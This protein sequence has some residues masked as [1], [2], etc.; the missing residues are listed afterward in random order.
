MDLPDD[1]LDELFAAGAAGLRF[2]APLSGGRADHLATKL[3][4]GSP[5]TVVDLGCGKGELLMAIAARLLE[6][7]VIGVDTDEELINAATESAARASLDK[8]VRF[9]VGDAAEWTG[10]T[11]AVICVGASHVFGG[12]AE[13]LSRF[14]EIMPEGSV[15]IGDGFWQE[16]PTAWCLETFGELPGSL[17]ELTAMAEQAGWTVDEAAVS[18]LDEWDEFEHR[19]IDGVRRVGTEHATAFADMRLADYQQYRG[20]L[21]FGWLVLSR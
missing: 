6:T 12:S 17:G 2:N 5:R 11:D 1:V 13:M 4:L 3:G 10:Q 8:R 18:S 7:N 9:V 19:W 14:A 15:V 20:V 21:G 16:A